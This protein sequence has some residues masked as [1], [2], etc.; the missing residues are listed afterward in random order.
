[1]SD[2]AISFQKRKTKQQILAAAANLPKRADNSEFKVKKTYKLSN[3]DK[4]SRI[5]AARPTKVR[6]IC[7]METW[8]Y[9]IKARENQD[10]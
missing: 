9:F 1:M 2:G 3:R 6:Y 5:R 10:F 7:C 4:N 8:R